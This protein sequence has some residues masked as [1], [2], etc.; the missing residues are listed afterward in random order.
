MEKGGTG[1]PPTSV[2]FRSLPTTEVKIES[3]SDARKCLD[4]VKKMLSEFEKFLTQISIH[5]KDLNLTT[6][7]DAIRAALSAFENILTQKE[8]LL[9][10]SVTQ[11]NTQV[12]GSML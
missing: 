6:H 1:I 3:I 2:R 9:K 7:S 10:T 11:S 5:D 8:S 4:S 12:Q